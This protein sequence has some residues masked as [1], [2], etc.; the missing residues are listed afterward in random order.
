MTPQGNFLVFDVK[1]LSHKLV[2]FSPG[3]RELILNFIRTSAVNSKVCGPSDTALF[4]N[5]YRTGLHPFLAARN[6][7]KSCIRHLRA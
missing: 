1:R 7:D 3:Y 2:T 5:R 6:P 4:R